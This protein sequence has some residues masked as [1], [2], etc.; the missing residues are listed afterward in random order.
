MYVCMYVCMGISCMDIISSHVILYNFVKWNEN[1]L[2][3]QCQVEMDWVIQPI[4]PACSH[5]GVCPTW[6]YP[7]FAGFM[8][9]NLIKMDDWG[10]PPF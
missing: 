6:G 10:V 1:L 8:M 5:M 2:I 3:F 7:Q 4:I 9:D